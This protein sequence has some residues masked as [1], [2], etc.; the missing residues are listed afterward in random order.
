MVS[1]RLSLYLHRCDL[2]SLG[3]RIGL[4]HM[5]VDSLISI[6]HTTYLVYVHSMQILYKENLTFNFLK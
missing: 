3:Q 1:V 5:L 2:H 6:P 4:M